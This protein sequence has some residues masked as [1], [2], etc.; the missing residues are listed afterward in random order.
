M[1]HTINPNTGIKRV[2]E[3]E[4]RELAK[5]CDLD[6]VILFGS[7]ARG[8][9]CLKSDIDLAVSGRNVT[10]FILDIDECTS[11]LLSFDVIDLNKPIMEELRCAIQ[12]E[13]IVLY[14]KV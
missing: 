11:T 14:E 4:I 2:V 1:S 10:R 12:A 9:H 5:S 3:Q 8:S 13:G 7:R 6:R